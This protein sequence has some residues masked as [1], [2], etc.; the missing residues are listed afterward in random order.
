MRRVRLK[1]ACAELHVEIRNITKM[2]EQEMAR[3]LRKAD[4]EDLIG[5]FF[6]ED[7]TPDIVCKVTIDDFHKLGSTD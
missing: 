7:V 3:I 5:N 4:K 6:E 2:A 1:S